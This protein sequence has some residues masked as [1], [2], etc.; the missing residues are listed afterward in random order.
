MKNFS[1][2]SIMTTSSLAYS[3][4]RFRA[5]MKICLRKYAKGAPFHEQSELRSS[6]E[7]L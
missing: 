6:G 4:D 7:H 5:R 1:F 3:V 2:F